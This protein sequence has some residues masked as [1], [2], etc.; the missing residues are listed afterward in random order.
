LQGLPP[1]PDA[2]PNFEGSWQKDYR[3]SDDVEQKLNL[4]LAAIQRQY[5]RAQGRSDTNIS[6]GQTRHR[7][8]T[9]IDLARFAELISRHNDIYISQTEN[10]VRIKRD[11]EADLVCHTDDEF[12][13]SDSGRL[14]S[15][16]CG[17]SGNQLLFQISLPGDIS[18]LYRFTVSDDRNDLNLQKRISSG[19]NMAFDLEEFFTRYEAMSQ[20]YECVLTLTRGRVCSRRGNNGMGSP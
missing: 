6:V 3:R 13:S 14:G 16:T 7:G 10:E 11:G 8:T 9:I 17:W 12:I 2:R 1:D 4:T 20:E 15:E 19:A 5:E 18:V